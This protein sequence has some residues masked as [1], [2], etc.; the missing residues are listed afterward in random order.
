MV[1]IALN[2]CTVSSPSPMINFPYS[3][4]IG[5]S[6]KNLQ[7]ISQDNIYVWCEKMEFE[8]CTRDIIVCFGGSDVDVE[9]GCWK[10]EI[11]M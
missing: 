9:K 7:R 8:L 3:D 1:K 11:A 6:R 10:T 5:N 4:S 2:M